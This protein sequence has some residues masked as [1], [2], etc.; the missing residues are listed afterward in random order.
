MGEE[1]GIYDEVILVLGA[2]IVG[3]LNKQRARK[4][5]EYNKNTFII[6]TGGRGGF[7]GRYMKKTEAEQIGDYLC[8]LGIEKRLIRVESDAKDT[9]DN[10]RKS[11]SLIDLIH[12]KKVVVVTNKA[13]MKRA[14]DYAK[15]ILPEYE[16]VACP[17]SPKWYNIIGQFYE[18]SCFVY[19]KT[20]IP[21]ENRLYPEAGSSIK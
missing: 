13:H 19:E 8:E 16:I 2:G 1:K 4:A 20:K 5:V 7:L 11:K 12:P 14:V 15:N 17:T 18:F 21:I 6:P 9:K 10:F 3:Y